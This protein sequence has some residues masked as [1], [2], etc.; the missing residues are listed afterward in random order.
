M[1]QL[2]E[3]KKEYPDLRYDDGWF[4]LNEKDLEEFDPI[5]EDLGGSPENLI[6]DHYEGMELCDNPNEPDPTKQTYSPVSGHVYIKY[7][8]GGDYQQAFQNI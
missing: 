4:F 1:T 2:E 3:L 7:Q 8:F 6:A 5:I